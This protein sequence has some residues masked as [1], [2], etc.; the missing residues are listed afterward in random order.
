M[1]DSAAE[2]IDV[3]RLHKSLIESQLRDQSELN[4]ITAKY[5]WLIGYH[6]AAVRNLSD[7]TLLDLKVGRESLLISTGELPSWGEISS[8]YPLDSTEL[9]QSE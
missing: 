9:Q 6:N 4:G 7:E 8:Q 5:N 1:V 2:A 3:L